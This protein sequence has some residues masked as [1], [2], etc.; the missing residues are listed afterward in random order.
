MG[1]LYNNPNFILTMQ[2][3]NLKQNLTQISILLLFWLVG[4][5]ISYYLISSIPGSIIGMILLTL[6]LEFKIIKLHQV[7]NT[8]NFL[9]K[10]MAFFFIPPGVGVMVNLNLIYNN[11]ITITLATI[12][13]TILVLITTALVAQIGQNK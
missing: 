11:W 1:R 3:K 6:A 5:I 13:S 12:G 9:I 8:S 2:A 7:E 4:E 10:N